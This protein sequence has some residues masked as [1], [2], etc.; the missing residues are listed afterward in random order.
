MRTR[1]LSIAHATADAETPGRFGFDAA[2]LA[3]HEA[4][5]HLAP[6]RAGSSR[7]VPTP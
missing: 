3:L 5:A 1:P 6:G 4:E 7:T 2:E